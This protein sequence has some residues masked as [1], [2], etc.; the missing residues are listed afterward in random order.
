MPVKCLHHSLQYDS[1][2]HPVAQVPDRVFIGQRPAQ[3]KGACPPAIKSAPSS[4]RVETNCPLLLTGIQGLK[5]L[6]HGMI[7]EG[8]Q[9]RNER[10]KSVKIGALLVGETSSR[11]TR[12]K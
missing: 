9:R 1:L 5:R 11:Y 4:C 2:S 7:T 6:V 10:L 12:D 8:L 3:F